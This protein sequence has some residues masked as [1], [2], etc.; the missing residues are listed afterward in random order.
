MINRE[1]NN[2]RNKENSMLVHFK[3][4]EDFIEDVKKYPE[5][6]KISFITRELRGGE[7]TRLDYEFF[8]K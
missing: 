7:P 1:K 3:N 8:K 6:K 4:V 5:L 2:S